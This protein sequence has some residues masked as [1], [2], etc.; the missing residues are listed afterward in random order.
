M[1][2]QVLTK[3]GFALIG[4]RKGRAVIQEESPLKRLNYFDGK[5]LRAND[6]KLEQQ[7]LLNQV[8][9][10][11]QAGGAG[12]VHGF[13]CSLT[14]GDSLM[15]ERGM[16]IDPQGRILLLPG[17]VNVG[18][19]DLIERS[20]MANIAVKALAVKEKIGSG[21]TECV[22]RTEEAPANIIESVN[23]YLVTVGHVEAFCG[24]ED[25]FGKLCEEACISSTERPYIIE[26][27]VIWAVP[28]N[29]TELL[30]NSNKISLLTRHLR[31]QVAS[32][33]FKQEQQQPASMIS[34]EGLSS[35]TWCR[36]TEAL[37]GDQV[38]IAVLARSGSDTLFLD[39]WIARRERIEPPSRAY[40][41]HRMAMRPWNIF[42]AQVLQ[43]QCQLLTCIQKSKGE[44]I[45]FDPC[46]NE[47]RVAAKVSEAMK[48]LYSQYESIAKSFAKAEKIEKRLETI[49]TAQFKLLQKDLASIVKKAVSNRYLISCGIVELPSAGYLP[50]SSINAL[51]VNEQVRRMMGE[52]VD[53]RFCTARPDYVAHALEQAQHMERISLL[54]GIDNPERKPRVDVIVPDGRIEEY[55]ETA[56]GTG[57]EMETVVHLR[58]LVSDLA[59]SGASSQL[60]KMEEI[61]SKKYAL[62]SEMNRMVSFSKDLERLK[63]GV[64]GAARGERLETGG[65]AFHCAAKNPGTS[66]DIM[67]RTINEILELKSKG[68]AEPA[69]PPAG[70]GVRI[71]RLA[72]GVRTLAAGIRIGKAKTQE[73]SH[74]LWA[75]LR[76]DRDPFDMSL[77]Q[78]TPVKV[79]IVFLFSYVLGKIFTVLLQEALVSGQ[80]L[81]KDIQSRGGE[82]QIDGR[83]KGKLIVD[84]SM[85]QGGPLV[86]GSNHI[87]F[88]ETVHI[89]RL[90]SNGPK[91]TI[92]VNIP[93]ASSISEIGNVELRFQHTWQDAQ[94]AEFEAAIVSTAA[95]PKEVPTSG[96][97]VEKS[98]VQP[99][100]VPIFSGHRT[101]NNDVLT[102]RHPLHGDS[103][104]ALDHLGNALK[105]PEFSAF[106]AR[107]LFPPPQPVA[108]EL[109]VYAVRDWVLFHRRREIVCGLDR[110]PRAVIQ[111]CSYRLFHINV[112]NTD[113]L[114]LL[115]RALEENR[116]EL[117]SRF[118]PEEVTI[119]EFE[120][121]I[122]NIRTSHGDICSDWR[123]EVKIDADISLG[124]IASRG[125]AYDQGTTLA[126]QR[127]ESLVRVLDSVTG[128]AEDS[129]LYSIVKIPDILP[130][131][132]VDGIIVLATIH[133]ETICH[134]VFHMEGETFDALK[135]FDENGYE[136][137][138][139]AN[140]AYLLTI[141]AKFR[142][143]TASLMFPEAVTEK[144]KKSWSDLDN[145]E[146][147]GVVTLYETDAE[148]NAVGGDKIAEQSRLLAKIAKGGIDPQFHD[149][150]TV[151]RKM[152]DCP[153]ITVLATAVRAKPGFNDVYIWF[154]RDSA[155]ENVVYDV[156]KI[157]ESK[158]LPQTLMP[159][160]YKGPCY[161]L[162][163]VEFTSRDT[164]VELSLSSVV[165]AAI[166]TGILSS[167]AEPDP[168][169]EYQ[170]LSVSQK[171]ADEIQQNRDKAQTEVIMKAMNFE[172]EANQAK[173]TGPNWPSAGGDAITFILLPYLQDM[174]YRAS[175]VYTE[176]AETPADPIAGAF[177]E[178]GFDRSGK[179]IKNVAYEA[180]IARLE[181]YGIKVK[182][183]EIVMIEAPAEGARDPRMEAL[184]NELKK[185]GV[186]EEN[187]MVK[188]RK[189]AA[190]ERK[191]IEKMG[192]GVTSGFVF[193]K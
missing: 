61:P 41:A 180:G 53:L 27:V 17:E 56:P 186:A 19:A 46:E 176:E 139:E 26:G 106:N 101:I 2:E 102:P 156:K 36:G 51:T 10:S 121:G 105:D 35:G 155:S 179:L 67:K 112:S 182:D 173:N 147:I 9:L 167:L 161:Q 55:K 120:A 149:V 44:F 114:A 152:P 59:A 157:I 1:A 193:R 116:G 96:K 104:K 60:N 126:E 68:K 165:T 15:V 65:H 87:K 146:L 190:K 183:I 178:V 159:T 145:S 43:F 185:A 158:G 141:D 93:K 5:F 162:G 48:S 103:L 63:G 191:L 170:I 73:P 74:V 150:R 33:F 119:V 11:N 118:S 192:A 39:A 153:A 77:G 89:L 171:D 25:V 34:G 117:I 70:S 138:L 58:T 49:D 14:S 6:L 22:E 86:L 82:T 175:Y 115:Q 88:D 45:K 148:G 129:K 168:K 8:R 169:L 54:E 164:A 3:S 130:H 128:L 91:D 72:E 100:A 78:A 79:E 81:V 18:I 151:A 95:K 31:S 52:G 110:I 184:L 75:S 64:L 42:L 172:G 154:V 188:V 28:L 107:L 166:A 187:A 12:P 7:A 189:A 134:S 140:S 132:E 99:R 57:Y 97:V 66:E 109:K 20:R 80:L 13:H 127:L 40:W 108:T 37:G 4:G 76:I 16:A 174:M 144:L 69:T 131:G 83:L 163:L 84:A 85:D 71:A 160:A 123:R 122:Q 137:W 111:P 142:K 98:I 133:V 94:T 30:V 50:V 125:A 24:S 124:V 113:E 135:K 62:Y 143:D 21:F 47:R 29:L 90:P 177:S 38:P 181:K 32:A 23:L 92:V 136:K